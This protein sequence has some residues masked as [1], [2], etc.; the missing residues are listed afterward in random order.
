MRRPR[1]HKGL[2]SHWKN[3]VV[4][5][6]VVVAVVICLNRTNKTKHAKSCHFV[7]IKLMVSNTW[8]A[9]AGICTGHAPRDV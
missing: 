5:V 9:D 8:T 2:S 7:A 3:I 4:V 1:A 6:V